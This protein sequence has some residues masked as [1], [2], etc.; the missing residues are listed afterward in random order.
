MNRLSV[1]SISRIGLLIALLSLGGALY[2]LGF[3]DGKERSSSSEITI[4]YPPETAIDLEEVTREAEKTPVSSSNTS[5]QGRLVASQ[6][7][8]RYYTPNCPGIG[9]IHEE[10]KIYFNTSE[11]AKAQGYTLAQ[12]CD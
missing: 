11:D 5:H 10:N 2:M 4:T 6:N 9:R 3:I 7:G 8:T 1:K 12:A